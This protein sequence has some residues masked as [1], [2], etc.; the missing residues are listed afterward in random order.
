M[1]FLFLPF[2]TW[3]PTDPEEEEPCT[4]SSRE[5]PPKALEFRERIHED[6]LVSDIRG[7]YLETIARIS[8]G[9][10]NNALNET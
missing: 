2:L 3:L 5:P 1:S 8:R 6:S 9:E 10:R 7:N 4:P